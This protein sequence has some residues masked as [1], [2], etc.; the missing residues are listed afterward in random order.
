MT[1]QN[2]KRIYVGLLFLWCVGLGSLPFFGRAGVM[3]GQTMLIVA[4]AFTTAILGSATYL[5][6]TYKMK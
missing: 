5:S 3:T 4:A 6:L 2:I 1:S